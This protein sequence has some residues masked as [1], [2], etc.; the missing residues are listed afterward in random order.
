MIVLLPF[1]MPSLPA[2]QLFL[3]NEPLPLYLLLSWSFVFIVSCMNRGGGVI[4]LNKSNLLLAT[5]LRTNNSLG[6]GGGGTFVF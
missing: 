5:L 6:R 1:L 2:E 3:P 4:Y